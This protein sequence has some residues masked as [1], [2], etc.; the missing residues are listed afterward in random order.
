MQFSFVSV[1]CALIFSSN[2]FALLFQPTVVQDPS[3]LAYVLSVYF[4]D[5]LRHILRHCPLSLSF[6]ISQVRTSSSHVF[7][8]SRMFWIINTLSGRKTSGHF[9]VLNVQYRRFKKNQSQKRTRNFL[10][11][12]HLQPM[13]HFYMFEKFHV[14]KGS[15]YKVFSLPASRW[16]I[17]AEDARWPA[18]QRRASGPLQDRSLPPQQRR[19]SVLVLCWIKP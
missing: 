10:H 16:P 12:K 7:Q 5:I 6:P 9:S 18:N 14:D 4:S 19:H 13:P 2:S 15:A 17:A 8:D 11:M 1:I 3:S